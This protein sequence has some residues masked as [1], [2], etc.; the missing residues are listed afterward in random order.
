MERLNITQTLTLWFAAMIF[1]QTGSGN[2]HSMTLIA[3]SV[4][5]AITYLVPFYLLGA[6]VIGIQD[7]RSER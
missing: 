4:A 6:V 7:S 3:A 5:I 2:S 1:L